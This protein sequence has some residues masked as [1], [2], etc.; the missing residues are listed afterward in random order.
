M[1]GLPLIQYWHEEKPPDYIVALLDTFREQN[2][3]M[4]HLIFSEASAGDFIAT[5]Y[6]PRELAAFRA[7]GAPAMQADYLRYC[8]AH[9]LGGICVDADLLCVRSLQSML[10]EGVEG[11]LFGRHLLLTNAVFGFCSPGHPL[12]GLT[13]DVV[14]QL[15][16]QRYPGT[17]DAVTGPMIFSIL[18]RFHQDSSETFERPLRDRAEEM[19]PAI[20]RNLMTSVAGIV[21]DDERLGYA[22]E[23][24]QVSRI[25][26]VLRWVR[27][28]DVKMAY[29]GTADDWRQAKLDIY[30]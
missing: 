10:G 14:T 18:H 13:I 20:V 27:R 19:G 6:G 22:F 8:A 3:E 1:L 4:E 28:P 17:V 21:A 15:I 26:S 25:Q 30:R 16:E 2:P 23:G 5:H 11:H 12:L 24:V 7:C 9:T 29:K